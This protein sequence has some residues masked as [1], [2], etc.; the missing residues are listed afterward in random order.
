VRHHVA[1]AIVAAT[2][3]VAANQIFADAN[4]ARRSGDYA[5]ALA[6]YQKLSTQF[7]GTREAIT[8]HMIVGEL[9]LA[10]HAPDE[11]LK[12]F[13]SYLASSPNGTLA[14]EARVGRAEALQTLG[15]AADERAAWQD[16]LR[17]HPASVHAQR[18]RARLNQLR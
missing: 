3:P 12:Q 4:R 2:P 13:D 9:A 8:G 11:A 16:L 1:A 7:P 17:K 10:R 15:R 18:A 5:A 14:E 6:D